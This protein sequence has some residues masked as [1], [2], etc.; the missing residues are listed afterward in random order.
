MYKDVKKFCEEYTSCQINKQPTSKPP[1]KALAV[2]VPTSAWS[3]IAIDFMGSIS[4]TSKRTSMYIMVI[5]CRF[6]QMVHLI[7][8]PKLTSKIIAEVLAK[9]HIP[10]FGIPDDILSDRDPRFTAH[11]WKAVML[12][13]QIKLIMTTA[14]HQNT[15]GALE[16]LNKVI[17]HQLRILSQ[18]AR[19]PWDTVLYLIQHSINSTPLHYIDKSPFE[20]AFG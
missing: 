9:K 17:G 8:L 3:S 5:L 10:L 6:I 1:G 15:N 13:I 12:F 19:K 20:L 4:N 16:R 18:N 14:F 7:V 11:F 2:E